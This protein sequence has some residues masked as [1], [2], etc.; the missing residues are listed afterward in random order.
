VQFACRELW[1]WNL[2]IGAEQ[3]GQKNIFAQMARVVTLDLK[4]KVT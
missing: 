2:Q 3:L 4:M 1:D